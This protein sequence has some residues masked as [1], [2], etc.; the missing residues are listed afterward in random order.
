V[1][2]KN[3]KLVWSGLVRATRGPTVLAP[4]RV[5]ILLC[6]ENYP[7]QPRPKASS[8]RFTSLLLH[9]LACVRVHT[10]LTATHIQ[11][12]PDVMSSNINQRLWSRFWAPASPLRTF[13]PCRFYQ[14]PSTFAQSSRRNF[15]WSRPRP[16]HQTPAKTS[17]TKKFASCGILFL[18]LNPTS[19]TT[20]STVTACTTTA[21]KSLY[22]TGILPRRSIVSSAQQAW[23]R[24]MHSSSRRRERG[25]AKRNKS[26]TSNEQNG[27]KSLQ[28]GS[29]ASKVPPTAKNSEP[30]T[31]NSA[32]NSYLHLPHMPKM[33]HRPTK[34]ELLAAATG[35]WS[36][37]KVR[38][39]WFS[40]RSVRPWNIDDWS[41]FVSWFVLGNIAWIFI[42]TT[43]FFSLVIFSI[44]TVVAQG[45]FPISA[46]PNFHN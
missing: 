46:Y 34:E 1:V 41:A 26:S 19:A 7:A 14:K 8:I 39:K 30:A 36:R 10:C 22:S 13:K 35:F 31:P 5:C 28:N 6:R 11:D 45:L 16:Q 15:A 12:D 4:S 37:L 40:I 33:P 3:L 17:I 43:T 2:G 18:D 23:R 42:G 24:E 9:L 44:N 32:Y 20:S 21:E 25:H 38:F 29:G 27:R